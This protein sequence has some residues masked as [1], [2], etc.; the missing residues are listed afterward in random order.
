[1]PWEYTRIAIAPRAYLYIC[2]EHDSKNIPRLHGVP[3]TLS[4]TIPHQTN[5]NSYNG[6]R[7]AHYHRQRAPTGCR[8]VV[9]IEVVYLFTYVFFVAPS[10]LLI[11]HIG[12]MS[13]SG[14]LLFHY[15]SSCMFQG[16]QKLWL[17]SPEFTCLYIIICGIQPTQQT[18]HHWYHWYHSLHTATL[19]WILRNYVI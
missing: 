5:T 11:Y 14:S 16:G 17:N 10:A 8:L 12:L 1:M 6:G 7:Y 9:F 15:E 19:R 3:M 13:P 4:M 18:Y 2:I